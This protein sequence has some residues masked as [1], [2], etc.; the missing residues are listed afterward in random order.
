MLL[1]TGLGIR[2]VDV[3]EVVQGIVNVCRAVGSLADSH[4]P[5][6]SIILQW[7]LIPLL[8]Q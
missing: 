5:A 3:C 2:L 4:Q 6:Q 1:R 8:D 7:A